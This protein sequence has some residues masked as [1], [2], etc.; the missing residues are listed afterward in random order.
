MNTQFLYKTE[1]P[2][3]YIYLEKSITQESIEIYERNS[4]GKLVKSNLF[5]HIKRRKLSEYN[6][7][8][9]LIAYLENYLTISGWNKFTSNFPEMFI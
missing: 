5:S 4:K 9:N 3:I 1:Q 7:K 2:G 8:N 6:S